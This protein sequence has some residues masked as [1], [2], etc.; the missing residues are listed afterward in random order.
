VDLASKF[1][2]RAPA[3]RGRGFEGD[4]IASKLVV[5]DPA[6]DLDI[7]SLLLV[8]RDRALLGDV[9][10]ST[11]AIEDDGLVQEQEGGH[12]D[13]LHQRPT[14]PGAREQSRKPSLQEREELDGIP[15][16]M[17]ALEID[18]TKQRLGGLGRGLAAARARW[19]ALE[20][21]AG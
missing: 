18:G 14:E 1:R 16:R 4:R 12:G 10:T 13:A 17:E 2:G 11:L 3:C 15:G 20:E 21:L 6:H 19:L 7:E 8:R 9:A 5:D